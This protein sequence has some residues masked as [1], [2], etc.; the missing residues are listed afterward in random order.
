MKLQKQFAS[1]VKDKTYSK[2]VIILP[3]YAVD[4]AQFKEGDE[5]SI[6]ARKGTVTLRKQ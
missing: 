5:L 3:E 4:K 1:K 6:I 2:Y